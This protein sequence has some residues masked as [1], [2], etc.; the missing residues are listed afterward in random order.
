MTYLRP[1]V[2]SFLSTCLFFAVAFGDCYQQALALFGVLVLALAELR[3]L[4]VERDMARFTREHALS[5]LAVMS[6]K[7]GQ[8]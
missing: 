6:R 5:T 3:A 4:R 2:W 8:S 7:R 1:F